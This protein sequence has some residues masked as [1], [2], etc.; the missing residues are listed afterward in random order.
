MKHYEFKLSFQTYRDLTQQELMDLENALTLQ[1][2][3]PV[4]SNQENEEYETKFINCTIEGFD[5]DEKCCQHSK[6]PDC[7]CCNAVCPDCQDDDYYLI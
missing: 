4:N 5:V 3:E 7:D 6:D 2:E 1:I